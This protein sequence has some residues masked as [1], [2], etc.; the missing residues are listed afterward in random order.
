MP[1]SMAFSGTI[2]MRGIKYIL[3]TG[4][5]VV[6]MFFGTL[7]LGEDSKFNLPTLADENGYYWR[8]IDD[9]MSQ[10]EYRDASKHN[11]RVVT[12]MARSYLEEQ[13]ISLG[14]PVKG[15]SMAGVA[16]N[17]AVTGGKFNLN[18][19]K[20]LQLEF[21]DPIDNGRAMFLKFKLDW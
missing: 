14:I 1:L 18:K 11:Q 10:Q 7:T 8:Q 15:V 12:K 4:I 21:D 5:A 13:F 9:H 6:S 2:N 19:S 16:V 17:F 3:T 20:T